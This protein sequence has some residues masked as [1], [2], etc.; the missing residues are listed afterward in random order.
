MYAGRINGGGESLNTAYRQFLMFV[1][2]VEMLS[3]HNKVLKLH[4][5]L[6]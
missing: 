6:A 3:L 4:K 5:V 1:V 2:L